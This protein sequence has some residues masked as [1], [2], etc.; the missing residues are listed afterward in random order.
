MEG[1][2]ANLIFKIV[3]ESWKAVKPYAVMLDNREKFTSE[4]IVEMGKVVERFAKEAHLLDTAPKPANY[5]GET[6][7]VIGSLMVI[8]SAL[9]ARE[10]LTDSPEE[11]EQIPGQQDMLGLAGENHG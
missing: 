9:A 7:C 11:P 6:S 3:N 2:Y 8:I 5:N 10:G 4:K 1:K